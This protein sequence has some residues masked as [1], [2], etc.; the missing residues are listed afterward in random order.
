MKANYGILPGLRSIRRVTKSMR[1][2]AHR[3]KS[4][5]DLSS[6]LELVRYDEDNAGGAF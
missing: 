1:S 3:R 5:E 6:Y 4:L 2:L